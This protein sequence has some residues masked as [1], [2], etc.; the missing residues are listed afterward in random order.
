[1]IFLIAVNHASPSAANPPIPG[2]IYHPSETGIDLSPLSVL[3]VE[4][5]VD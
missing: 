2:T 5:G 1:M 3:E 4:V